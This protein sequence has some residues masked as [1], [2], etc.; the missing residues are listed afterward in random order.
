MLERPKKITVCFIGGN[1]ERTNIQQ[2]SILNQNMGYEFF[3]WRR[4]DKFEGYYYTWSQIANECIS[5]SPNEYIIFINPKVDPLISDIDH[6]IDKLISGYCF[7]SVIGTGYCGSTIELFRNIGLFDERYLGSEYEDDDFSLRLKMF[8]K[9]IIW[10]YD[11]N[12]YPEKESPLSPN[13]GCSIS[14]FDKKWEMI[15]DNV[16][17]LD[18]DLYASQKKLH[19][20]I[21]KSNKRDIAESW[22]EYSKSEFSE[23]HVGLRGNFATILEDRRKRITLRENSK[24]KINMGS[25]KFDIYFECPIQT[26]IYIIFVNAEDGSEFNIAGSRVTLESNTWYTDIIENSNGMEIK[27]FHECEKIYHDRFI[28]PPF[29]K[30]IE[31]GLRIT[32]KIL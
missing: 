21:L 12:R 15:S 30:E 3:F 4:C 13:R 32:Q 6:M 7:V 11:F 14:F 29:I 1:V 17:N 22:M 9:A 20:H 8:D 24:I 31:I 10:G 19:G 25:D 5:E 2:D 16:Y 27:I 26:K 23:Q 18:M 28:S